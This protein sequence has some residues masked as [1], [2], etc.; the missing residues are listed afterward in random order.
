MCFRSSKLHRLDCRCMPTPHHL[1]Q[2]CANWAGGLASARHDLSGVIPERH[3]RPYL[4]P[5]VFPGGR[6]RFGIERVDARWTGDHTT[7]PCRS[8]ALPMLFACAHS[9]TS[10]PPPTAVGR[11]QLAQCLGGQSA[12]HTCD[13]CPEHSPALSGPPRQATRLQISSSS[14]LFGA[15]R[16]PTV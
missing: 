12:C 13:Q 16:N 3:L 2:A 7:P 8:G 9:T 1:N 6:S 10:S 14:I 15:D 5:S 11:S 4:C